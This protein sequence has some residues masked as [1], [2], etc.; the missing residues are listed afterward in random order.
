MDI[1]RRHCLG[2]AGCIANT[3]SDH[4]DIADNH[5]WGRDRVSGAFGFCRPIDAQIDSAIVAKADD[6]LSGFCVEGQEIAIDGTHEDARSEAWGAGPVRDAAM[7]EAV[8]R[9]FA[10]GVAF[11]VVSP[12][13]SAGGGIDGG[14]LAESGADV[15]RAA[16]HKRRDFK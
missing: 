10:A 1:A 3:R 13:G 7:G 12:E 14:D 9:S 4:Y 11:G 15:K 6:R 16:D 5:G 8:K 2:G